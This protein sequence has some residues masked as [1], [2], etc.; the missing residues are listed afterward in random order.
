MPDEKT[1]VFSAM[2]A[3]STNNKFDCIEPVSEDNPDT[4]YKLLFEEFDEGNKK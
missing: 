2:K 4:I 3:E 1:G